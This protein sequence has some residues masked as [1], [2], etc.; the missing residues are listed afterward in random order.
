MNAH[1]RV[2]L[3]RRPGSPGH[4]RPHD[5]HFSAIRVS[6]AL[7]LIDQ[8]SSQPILDVSYTVYSS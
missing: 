5:A 7:F 2:N 6:S 4:S 3:I 8:V 1:D